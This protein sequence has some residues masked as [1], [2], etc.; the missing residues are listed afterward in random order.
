MW[1]EP[2]ERV[3][4]EFRAA[5]IDATIH[6][7]PADV[8]TAEAAATAIGCP[9]DEIVRADVF[10]CDGRPVVALVP[11]D[12]APDEAKVALAAECAEIRAARPAEVT[13]ATGFE[14][15]AVAPFPFPGVAVVLLERTVLHHLRVWVSAGSPRHV[16][17]LSTGEL[18]LLSGAETADLLGPRYSSTTDR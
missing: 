5:A 12:R 1:P 3:A 10:I 2:V 17:A 11:G 8:T 16:A 6:E 15:D 4:R 9:L 14:P 18:Q 7:L 13:K